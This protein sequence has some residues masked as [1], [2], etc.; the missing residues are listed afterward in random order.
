MASVALVST[1]AWSLFVVIVVGVAVNVLSDRWHTLAA[2][3][4]IS[5]LVA[6]A[7]LGLLGLAGVVGPWRATKTATTHPQSPPVSSSPS[8]RPV[9]STTPTPTRPYTEAESSVTV[10]NQQR[11]NTYRN[12]VSAALGETIVFQVWYWNREEPD[13]GKF[14]EGLT[15]RVDPPYRP[16]GSTWRSV[17]GGINTNRSF[18]SVTVHLPQHA[19]LRYV[20]GSSIWRHNQSG[21]DQRVKYVN[22]SLPDGILDGGV[23]V[24]NAA[25]CWDC[26]ATV[27]FLAKVVSD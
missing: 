26:E 8:S 13:S 2:S 15:L 20:D 4:Q 9:Q 11:D 1:A 16:G 3:A 18:D 7:L 5:W 14:A 19:H 6:A 22:E 12:S 21:T 17:V 23:L 24:E 25:P 10:A 27:S